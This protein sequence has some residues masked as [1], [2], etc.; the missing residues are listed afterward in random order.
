MTKRLITVSLGLYVLGLLI[1]AIWARE[2]NAGQRGFAS[3]YLAPIAI[4]LIL[5][6]CGIQLFLFW[7]RRW[8]KPHKQ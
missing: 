1:G 8:V 7:K 6:A 2:A 4:A 3:T 5:T